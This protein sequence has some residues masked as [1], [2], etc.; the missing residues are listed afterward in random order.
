METK[1]KPRVYFWERMIAERI[2]FV[3]NNM[4]SVAKMLHDYISADLMMRIH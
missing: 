2:L 4:T 1:K 3:Y